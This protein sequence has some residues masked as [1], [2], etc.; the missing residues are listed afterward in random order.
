MGNALLLV[1]P[2]IVWIWF[3][4]LHQMTV[5]DE[6]TR[7]WFDV[8][9]SY[10]LVDGIAYWNI[11][12]LSNSIILSTNFIFH[13][14]ILLKSGLSTGHK[15]VIP[16]PSIIIHNYAWIISIHRRNV[17]YCQLH[18]QMA[19]EYKN[20]YDKSNDDDVQLNDRWSNGMEKWSYTIERYVK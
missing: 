11:W 16:F 13:R 3:D 8:V 7:F 4:W 2:V 6:Q 17:G 19:P 20:G 14:N 9:I 5:T 12:L 10:N 15:Q 18:R 1:C